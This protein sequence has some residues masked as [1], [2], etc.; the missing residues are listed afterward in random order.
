MQESTNKEKVLKKVRKALLHKTKNP[1]PTLDYDSPV[2]ASA[3]E[4]AEIQFA[5]Q[6]IKSGG[7]FVFCESELEFAENLIALAEQ[8]KWSRFY[9]REQRIGYFFDN[10]EFPYLDKDEDLLTADVGV[11]LCECLVARTGSVIISSRQ[12]SGRKLA[13]YVPVHVVLAYTSQ[14]VAE[15][16]DGL[17]LIKS[18]YGDNLPSMITT[19]TGPSRT[20]DIEKTIVFGAHGPK[21]L[22]VFL[23][24][25]SAN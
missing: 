16:K 22:Y 21:E 8:R 3:G 10:Y 24:D 20:A 12:Q 11:S 4:S 5:E 13:A 2:Y 23:I 9:C 15:L 17:S 25:D 19:I 6:L 1:Y 18:K 14:L 7:Q